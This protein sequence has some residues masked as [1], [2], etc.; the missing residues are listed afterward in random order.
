[1]NLAEVISVL[2]YFYFLSDYPSHGQTAK[3]S[4]M[5]NQTSWQK[6]KGNLSINISVGNSCFVRCPGCYNH[7]GHKNTATETILNFLDIVKLNNI[8]KVTLCGGDPLTRPDIIHLLEEIKKRRFFINLDTVG[9]SILGDV[10]TGFFGTHSIERTDVSKIASLVDM[11]GIPLDGL[12]N[13]YFQL[14]RKNRPNI[15]NEQIKIINLLSSHHASIGLNTVVHKGNMAHLISDLPDIL[16]IIPDIVKWQFFQFMPIG[17]LGYKNRSDYM[18]DDAAFEEFTAKIMH[19]FNSSSVQ[20]VE[21]KSCASRNTNYLLIDSDGNAW[22]PKT[23]SF[24]RGD[25]ISATKDRLMIGNIQKYEDY[26]RILEVVLN[27]SILI[28]ENLAQLVQN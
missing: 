27:P 2:F 10:T 9:T 24:Q 12:N 4:L 20:K 16:S 6:M 22:I 17:P 11:I 14:F 25:K 18:V 15:Y 23:S 13:E 3:F 7:F 1:M 19:Y 5:N 8:N 26:N 28:E 21:F